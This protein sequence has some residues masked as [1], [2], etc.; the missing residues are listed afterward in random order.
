MP[1]ISGFKR[2]R[3]ENHDFEAGLVYTARTY[4]KKVAKLNLKTILI[5]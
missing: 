4:F 3:Q 2:L 1:V 5:N